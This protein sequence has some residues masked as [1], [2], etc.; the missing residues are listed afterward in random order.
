MS[1]RS[2]FP[3]S[4]RSARL[5][6]LATVMGT[7]ALGLGLLGH[8]LLGLSS[9]DRLQL[10][11]QGTQLL[12]EGQAEKIYLQ[13]M[14][15][16]EPGQIQPVLDQVVRRRPEVV[17]ISVKDAQDEVIAHQERAHDPGAPSPQ[18]LLIQVSADAAT[19]GAGLRSVH[20]T[21]RDDG[22]AELQHLRV[23]TIFALLALFWALV[24]HQIFR[25]W[26]CL[27]VQEPSRRLALRWQ[28]ATAEAGPRAPSPG[29]TGLLGPAFQDLQSMELRRTRLR[30]A[31]EDRLEQVQKLLPEHAAQARA[32]VAA[33]SP[34]RAASVEGM[35][36]AQADAAQ[37]WHRC[38]TFLAGSGT[39]AAAWS[40]LALPMVWPVAAAGL[41]SVAWLARN[42]QGRLRVTDSA[43]TL[44]T[45]GLA[46][47][48]LGHALGGAGLPLLSASLGAGLVLLAATLAA[49]R[50]RSPASAP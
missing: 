40:T 6:L 5:L 24:A 17:S 43:W 42:G 7:V 16:E 27:Q 41:A 44:A 35:A 11:H 12:A 45:S 20:L 50:A 29:G 37:A 39:V 30:Q 34:S 47:A 25:L 4:S 18:A 13:L 46:G 38:A 10:L 49:T 21:V 1:Q 32:I 23:L 19:P 33:G 36:D 22:T 9:Q 48:A 31:L 14:A 26:W 3:G 2:S 15:E 28:N 8:Q